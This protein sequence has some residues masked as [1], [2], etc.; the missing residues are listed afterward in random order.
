[1][2]SSIS[3]TPRFLSLCA[4][5]LYA[6]L[7]VKTGKVQGKTAAGHTSAEFISFLTEIVERIQ[8]L[9]RPGEKF[10]IEPSR[11][12]L[13]TAERLKDGTNRDEPTGTG[14]AR[15]VETSAGRKDDAAGSCRTDGS[16]GAVGAEVAAA[17]EE[18]G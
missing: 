11:K 18:A 14:Q 8:R 13:L 4:A 7:D 12:F 10:L 9:S 6:A 5:S 16:D 15:L 17:D 1:M 2:V 3:G